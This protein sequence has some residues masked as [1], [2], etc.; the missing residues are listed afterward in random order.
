MSSVPSSSQNWVSFPGAVLLSLGT[1]CAVDVGL[2]TVGSTVDGTAALRAGTSTTVTAVVQ[3]AVRLVQLTVQLFS[4]K[5][6]QE[7]R[8][9]F[10]D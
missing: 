2:S 5:S 8:Q 3:S 7:G 9:Q 10:R 1:V 6:H 4:A